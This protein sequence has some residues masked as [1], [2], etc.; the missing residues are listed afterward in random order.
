[1]LKG[2]IRRTVCTF[3]PACFGPRVRAMAEGSKS[4]GYYGRG[5]DVSLFGVEKCGE[6]GETYVFCEN[7]ALRH[8][9]LEVLG[10]NFGTAVAKVQRFWFRLGAR[11]DSG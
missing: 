4:G 6:R 5:R 1:M 2:A 9:A 7:F 8:D 11:L 3:G 10:N